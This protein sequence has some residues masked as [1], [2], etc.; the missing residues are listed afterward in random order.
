MSMF[1]LMMLL[2]GCEDYGLTEFNEEPL[3]LDDTPLYILPEEEI[4][5]PPTPPGSSEWSKIMLIAGAEDIW[6]EEIWLQ[7]L[8]ADNFELQDN[9]GIPRML[10]AGIEMRVD[11]WFVPESSGPTE[12]TLMVGTDKQSA[13]ELSKT[14]VGRAC[15]DND[16]DGYCD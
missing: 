2:S 16:Y 9:L 7:G 13:V 14:I 15:E 11:L 8:G 3:P 4:L 5:F 1:T 6:I 10:P 12:A